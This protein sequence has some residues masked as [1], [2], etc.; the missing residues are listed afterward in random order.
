MKDSRLQEEFY[1]LR[2]IIIE[3]DFEYLDEEQRNAVLSSNRNVLV[4]ACPG[5]GKTTALIN[6][7]KYLVKYGLTYNSS[8]VPENLNSDDLSIMKIFIEEESEKSRHSE[9]I[10]SLLGQRRINAS[11]IIV[12]TFTKAAAANMKRRYEAINEN[13]SVPFFGTFHGLFYKILVRHINKINII[14]GSEEYRIISSVL[15]KHFEEINDDKVKEIRNTISLFKSSELPLD[16]FDKS[17][18][19]EIF[20]ECYVAYEGYK[21]EKGLLDFDDLQLKCRELFKNKSQMRELYRKSFQ[22]M[23]VDEFQDV[24]HI[25]LEIL[26]ILNDKNHLFALGDEDQCIYSFRGS[27]P[28]YM[29]DFHQRFEDA[30][31]LTLSTNYRSTRNVVGI[32]NNLIRNNSMRNEKHMYSNREEKKIIEILKYN[33][34]NSQSNDIALIIEKLKSLGNYDYNENA[35]LYRTNLESRSIIDAF[36]RKKIPFSLLDK[37]YN[38]FEHFICK[39]ILAYLRLSIMPWD[40]ESFKR[41]INKPFRYISKVNIEKLKYSTI[42]MDYFE[43]LKNMEAIPVFQ[44]KNLDKIQKEVH[45]LNKMSLHTA[46]QYILNTLGYQDYIAEYSTKYKIPILE[47]GEIIEE[48][49]EAANEY[50]SIATFLAHVES[51][52]EELKNKVKDNNE[53]GVILSTIHGVKGMEFK[54]VFIMNTVEESIPHANNMDKDIEEE[55]RL[56]FVGITRTVDNLYICIPKNIRAKH[57]KPSRFIEECGIDI[58]ENFH[59]LYKPNDSI[60]HNSFGKG[61]VK[62]MD[63]NVITIEFYDNIERKF[64]ITILHNN[65]IIKKIEI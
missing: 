13:T 2:D 3:R 41:I 1:R 49:K 8:Y 22:H 12:I 43:Q 15:A 28:D 26:K 60:I 25:Q 45:S 10:S 40:Y 50:N 38:F 17:I 4:T 6:R 59:E 33:D 64:D 55:R 52:S 35:V 23:L 19:K 61:I 7:V 11:N 51:V 53:D 42:K 9:R 36:I 39:D 30:V 32:S 21:E 57:K 47:L 29:V 16:D 65:G 18:D 63:K 20:M 58:Y 54:N 56:F 34:E 27:R 48:F 37:E 44:I 24:D 31:K 62:L 46:V 14:K 5:S